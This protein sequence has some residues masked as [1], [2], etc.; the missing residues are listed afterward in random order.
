MA[1]FECNIKSDTLELNVSVNVIIPQDVKKG[2]K[3][4]AVYLLHGYIGNHTDWCR[5][6]S[7]ERYAWEHRFAIIM[8]A[9]NNS[10]YANTKFGQ[11]YLDYVSIELPEIMSKIFPISEQRED[12]F[13]CGLSMGGYGALRVA[14]HNPKRFS[15]A[16]SLSGAVNIDSIKKL[17]ENTPRKP[18]TNATFG[19]APTKNTENDLLYLIQTHQKNK[20]ELPEIY[21][22][23]GT[24]D[25]LY[26]DNLEFKNEL[27]YLKVSYTYEESKGDHN[28]AFWDEYLK[29][30]LYWLE[31]KV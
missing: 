27:D 6:S 11:R 23:C 12:N 3:L 18:F 9:V 13:V 7:V 22:A 2:E 20:Q 14:L 10:Y 1:L 16:A 31:K 15:K 4:Q 17:V 30:V 8:P 5:Y 28:W 26:Q 25:F 24:E 19:E 29:K 21:F